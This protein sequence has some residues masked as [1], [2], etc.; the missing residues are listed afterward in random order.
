[1][2]FR[3]ACASSSPP[4]HLPVRRE[5][6][7]ARHHRAR[8]VAARRAAARA[9]DE[10]GDLVERLLPGGPDGVAHE[11]GDRAVGHLHLHRRSTRRGRGARSGGSSARK[12]A[13]ERGLADA[14]LADHGA[15]DELPGATAAAHGRVVGRVQ[16][17]LLGVAPDR[18]RSRRSA[19]SARR[20]SRDRLRSSA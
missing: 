17:G 4:P 16:V 20:S 19:I 9:R 3:R 14:H 11:L 15:A 2:F 13:D 7:E 10:R 5:L 18:D 8:R 1:M 12:V 6:G